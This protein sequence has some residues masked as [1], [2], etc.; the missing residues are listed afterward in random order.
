[1]KTNMKRLKFICAIF[2]LIIVIINISQV[3]LA[4][5][6][7]SV[8]IVIKGKYLE[9]KQDP[10]LRKARTYIPVRDFA[11]GLD[12]KVKWMAKERMVELS[13]ERTTILI[14][15]GKKEISIND[16]KIKVDE[17]NFIENQTTYIPLRSMAEALSQ[18]VQWDEQNR[19]A[20]IGKYTSKPYLEDTFLYTNEDHNYTINFP[21]SWKNDAVMETKD[22]N[23]YVYDKASYDKFK[24]KGFKNFASAFKVRVEKSPVFIRPPYEDIL[25]H[26]KDGKY[27]EASFRGDFQ[28]FPD[29]IETYKQVSDEA[30]KSLGSFKSLD[31]V[32]PSD[33]IGKTETLIYQ[34]LELE[35]TNVR[36][37]ASEKMVDS[38]GS[39]WD[40]KVFTCYPGANISVI[41][42][43]MND[44]RF[45]DSGTPYPNWAIDILNNKPTRIVDGLKSFQVTPDTIGIYNLESSL[46]VLK[47]EMVN[48]DESQTLY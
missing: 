12:L 19:I 31:L 35:V 25:L 28:Y 26:Y 8:D 11:R 42:A 30:E 36:N 21:N 4:A 1:M 10:I 40:Y 39:H 46:Y 24:E 16:K 27:V 29:T 20:I 38:G 23:L 5:G 17:R 32:T 34:G 18:E 7:S 2:V 3:T 22:G 14:P 44:G 13:N 15:V 33:K 47:F 37:I 45:T 9:M 43:G 41:N 48:L 6:R